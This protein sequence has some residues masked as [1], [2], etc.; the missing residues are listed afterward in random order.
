MTEEG[1][2]Q[3]VLRRILR[4]L[5]TVKYLYKDFLNRKINLMCFFVFKSTMPA[6]ILILSIDPISQ[7][8]LE[9]I[10]LLIN[11]SLT[12]IQQEL[13]QKIDLLSRYEIIAQ[14]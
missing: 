13:C 2:K 12:E 6:S 4:V 10:K 9:K 5:T 8:I 14:A 7:S 3:S 11:T 1:I